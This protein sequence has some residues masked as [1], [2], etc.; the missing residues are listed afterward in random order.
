VRLPDVELDDRRFQDLVNEAR[1]R[2]ARRCPEWTDHN[3]A[4]PGIVLTEL[5]AWMTDMTIYRLN[6][7]PD[8][9]HVHLLELLGIE[10]FPPIA[11]TTELRFRLAAPNTEPIEIPSGETEVGTRRTADEQSVVFRTTEQVVIPPA[12]PAAFAVEREENVREVGVADGV[13]EPPPATREPFSNPPVPGDALYLGFDTSLARLVVQIDVDCSQAGGAGI[14]PWD[15]PLRWEASGPSGWVEAEVLQDDT[16]GFNHGA[17]VIELQLPELHAEML[18]GERRAY[19]LRCRVDELTRSGQAAGYAAPPEIYRITAAPVGALVPA[20]HAEQVGEE[21]LGES[22]GTPAQSFRLRQCPVL[23]LETGETLEV[24][25]PGDTDWRAWERRDSFRESGPGDRHFRFDPS[26]GT[27]ALG[28]SIRS[29]D[30]GWN[31]HGAIPEK[32][33]LLRFSR[34]RHGGGP[35]GNVA[36]GKLVQLRGAIPGVA[37]VTNPAPAGGGVDPEPLDAARRRAALELRTRDRAVTREDY[38]YLATAA[39]RRVARAVCMPPADGGHVRVHVVPRLEAADGRLEPADL[40]AGDDLRAEVRAFLDERRPLGTAVEVLPVRVRGVSVVAEVAT[41]PGA[42]PGRAGTDV[43]AA[44]HA[45]LNPLEGGSLDGAG[46]GWPFGR[47]LN[48]GELFGV[49]HRVGAVESVRILRMY[50]TDLETG[51]R[52][53][54]AL[55]SHFV[56]EPDEVI[57][58]GDHV[59]RITG[60]AE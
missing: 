40:A 51:V 31:Q 28:P 60:Q 57:A 10:L 20:S 27:V 8:K 37:S 50:E 36:A 15:P 49:V 18:V 7:V 17:G 58:S 53:S 6:R 59:V 56:I 39:T 54:K 30:G 5:F 43:A 3:V 14:D 38:E 29:G 47:T 41:I 24:L 45:Y 32:G 21:E 19:W 42:D 12:R 22:D 1:M 46:E 9:L 23:P 44:L 16:G 52:S 33:A 55:G 4:N 25:E 11:A 2:I 26:S 48:L 34:Y 13:A 35:R